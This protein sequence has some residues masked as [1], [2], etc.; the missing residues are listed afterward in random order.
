MKYLVILAFFAII[1]SLASA[2]FFMMRSNSSGKSRQQKMAFALAMR[3]GIS[4]LLFVSIL[5]GWKLGYLHPTGITS[6]Q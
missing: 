2:L 6:G 4:I 3:V 5:L 1:A